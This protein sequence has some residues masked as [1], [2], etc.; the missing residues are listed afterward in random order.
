V[1]LKFADRSVEV[2]LARDELKRI[3]GGRPAL[4]VLLTDKA[5]LDGRVG[6]DLANPPTNDQIEARMVCWWQLNRFMDKWAEDPSLTPSI[7]IGV[8]GRP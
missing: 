2:P 6:M 8:S 7:L 5:F 3:T 4:F 1:P